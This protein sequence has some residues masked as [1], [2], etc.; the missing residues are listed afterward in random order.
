[1]CSL[2]IIFH[3]SI[4][5][6]N[7]LDRDDEHTNY[8]NEMTRYYRFISYHVIIRLSINREQ[9][10]YLTLCKHIVKVT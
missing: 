1:M 4:G 7:A 8:A 2:Y 10:K 3:V 6:L 9:L 5:R